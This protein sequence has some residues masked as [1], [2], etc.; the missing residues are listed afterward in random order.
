MAHFEKSSILSEDPKTVYAWHEKP[1]A[2]QRLL[3]PW[4]EIEVIAPPQK[5][6]NGSEVVTRMKVGPA[7]IN[8]VAKHFD[9]NPPHKFCDEQIEGPFASFRHQHIFDEAPQGT[10]MIDRVDYE[11][12]LGQLGSAL[13]THFTESRL[14]RLFSYRHRIVANDLK[15]HRNYTSKR[16]KIVVTGASGL[17]GSAL[18]PLLQSLGHDII[19]L[20]RRKPSRTHLTVHPW[21]FD[22][23]P[24]WEKW[25]I[26]SLDAVIHLAGENIAGARWNTEF[27]T[28]LQRSRVVPTEALAK[29]FK[30]LS[31]PPSVF[32]M[33]SATGFYSS[34][35]DEVTESGSSDDSFLSQLCQ[36]NERASDPAK[37]MNIRVLNLRIGMVLSPRGG[38]LQKMLLPFSTGLGGMLG[39]GKQYWS[40]IAIDDLIYA[41]VH[42]L[43]S[44]TLSG[45]VNCVS[46]QPLTNRDFSRELAGC[47][48]KRL[49]PTI[50][51]FALRALVGEMAD[52]LL[53]SSC[54]AAPQKLI[55][56]G[57]DFRFPVL[58]EA[59]HHVLGKKA[60]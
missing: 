54:R 26:D 9:V 41:I 15:I 25:G 13:G 34:S 33:A 59:L 17:V 14:E 45:P 21:T 47:Y 12:P 4:E 18:I 27:K 48:K 50:P 51:S 16:M 46:P 43:H 1:M 29:S 5:I 52:A 42:A 23:P 8:W 44:T 55:E 39:D 60:A 35:F 7:K 2:F 24:L 20:A 36:Q 10:K 53:L 22:S 28:K 40:W 11:L 56:S 3:P 31:K 30:S 58:R 57:F 49:G 19:I 6:E 32:M 37:E 38:A